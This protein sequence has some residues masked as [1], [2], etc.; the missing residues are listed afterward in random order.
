MIANAT[1]DDELETAVDDCA[2]ELTEA[3]YSIALRN[4]SVKNWLDLKLELW[5]VLRKTV[6]QWAQDWPQAGVMLVSAPAQESNCHE[7]PFNRHG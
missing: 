3:A 6:S 4:G 1:T 5:R 2:A 7:L